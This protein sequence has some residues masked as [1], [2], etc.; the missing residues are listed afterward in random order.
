MPIRHADPAR[1]AAACAAIYAPYVRDSVVSFEVDT[2]SEDDFAQRIE[3]ITRTHPWLVAVEAGGGEQED[4]G[5]VEREG[6]GAVVGFAYASPHKERAAYRWAADVAIYVDV[7]HRRR[8]LGREL[9]GALLPMLVRQGVRVACAGVT[10][11]NEGSVGLHEAFGFTPV[12]VY[13]R[14]GWKAGAW[15]DVGWWQL[16]LVPVDEDAGSPALPGP[17]ERA[18]GNR[19]APVPPPIP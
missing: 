9:Y 15:H 19:P 5:A 1:D 8:G 16:E 18:D 12:G 4:G 17:P 14:I 2:P 13:R 7:R 11:P 6:G 10:L 3:R